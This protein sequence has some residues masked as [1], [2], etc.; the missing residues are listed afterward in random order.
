MSDPIMLVANNIAKSYHDGARN[1]LHVLN[2][3]SFRL[4][5]AET[6]AIIGSSGSGKTTLLNILG[7]LDTPT[8]GQVLLNGEDVH[9][10]SE[11]QRCT[12]RNQHF[13]FI[14]QFHHLLPEFSALENVAMP[15]LINGDP[16]KQAMQRAEQVLEDVGLKQ[17]LSHK[18]SELSGGE[19]QRA[20]IARALIHRPDCIFA[21]EPTG[22]LDRKN[23]EQAIDLIINL[24]R[25]YHTSLIIVTH[26]VKIAE[27]MDTVYTLEDGV[28]AKA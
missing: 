24:N 14:Y 27:R 25:E 10:L 12:I 6:S 11:K 21:D 2:D 3:I 1:E 20:A 28:L 17:R 5:K 9:R 4:E 23:A 7:G 19:R 18:P 8:K 26:D 15:L 22:N 13:G 16:V